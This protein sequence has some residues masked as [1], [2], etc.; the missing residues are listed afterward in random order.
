MTIRYDRFQDVMEPPIPLKGVVLF[1]AFGSMVFILVFCFIKR[2]IT[3]FTLRSSHG[4]H[5]A[6]GANAP[7]S[8]RLEIERLLKR[9]KEITYEPQLLPADAE[10]KLSSAAAADARHYVYRMKTVDS[11]AVLDA[12]LMKCGMTMR[13]PSTPLKPF[14]L[15]ARQTGCPLE[16]ARLD[17]VEQFANCY[18]HARH[19]SAE[20]TV[21]HYEEFVR[22]LNQLLAHV[23]SKNCNDDSRA[24]IQE[25]KSSSS[26][27][28]A[29]A[30]GLSVQFMS[31][32]ASK[33]T[34]GASDTTKTSQ[35]I[36]NYTVA[37]ASASNN[38]TAR[39]DKD[40]KDIL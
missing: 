6:I 17:L 8:M 21:S 24:P 39:K 34:T 38:A 11:L 22:L 3:R 9:V 2:Q 10:E 33:L 16:G 29:S 19:D 26:K 1:I 7:K 35:R 31:P 37:S 28:D 23:R 27:T 32:T 25:A 15:D 30:A 36:A 12:E 14:L 4:P 5:A 40:T 13:K 18:E 20:F